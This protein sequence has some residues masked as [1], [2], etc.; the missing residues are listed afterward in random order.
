M[1]DIQEVQDTLMFWHPTLDFRTPSDY[2]NWGIVGPGSS[3]DRTFRVRN[4]SFLYTAEGVVVSLEHL[5]RYTPALPEPVQHFLSTNG[6]RFTATVNL[7]N[8]APRALSD[9]VTLRRVTSRDADEGLG[10]FHL[11]AEA[12]DWS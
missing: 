3:E 1:A 4:N 7:G 9:L 8:L 12:T 6:R 2:F 10:E 5:D 11:S